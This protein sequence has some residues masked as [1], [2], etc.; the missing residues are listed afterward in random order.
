MTQCLDSLLRSSSSVASSSHKDEMKKEKC[1]SGAPA[2]THSDRTSR[3]AAGHRAGSRSPRVEEDADVH[4]FLRKPREADRIQLGRS[5]CSHPPRN[6]LCLSF[7]LSDVSGAKP[8][9]VIWGTQSSP[10]R[11]YFCRCCT[12]AAVNCSCRHSEIIPNCALY[13]VQP[14]S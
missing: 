14:K 8:S 7:C 11:S 3:T 4:G 9:A 5:V 1:D 6:F 2:P 13:P 10:Q 12:P